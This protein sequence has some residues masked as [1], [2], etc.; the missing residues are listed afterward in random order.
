MF[1]IPPWLVQ[2]LDE[3]DKEIKKI[4]HSEIPQMQQMLDYVFSVKGKQIRPMMTFLCSR[5]TGKKPN[6]VQLAAVVEICHVASLIHDD[7]IDDGEL[8]RGH[9]TVQKKY[10]KEMAVYCGDYMIFA[11]ISR[12][13]LVNKLW[14]KKVFNKLEFMCNG[15]IKQ[16]Y[17]QHNTDVSEQEYIDYMQDKTSALFEIACLTGARE[18]KMN[19][20][21]LHVIENFARNFGI[22][23]QLVDDLSDWVCSQD[24]IKKKTKADFI[25]GYY[26]LPVIYTMQ[27]EQFAQQI[28]D[29]SAKSKADKNLTNN[30]WDALINAITQAGG[31]KY[32]YKMIDYYKYKTLD[33][34]NDFKNSPYKEIL[35]QITEFVSK[36]V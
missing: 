16:Y 23:F 24:K 32:T 27:N 4:C 3:T 14:Y 2:K 6:V 9:T 10:G 26:T 5:L 19:R 1:E 33:S 36:T 34:L 30:D 31:F 17:N 28:C 22:M 20:H 11:A 15:E 12:T 7:I 35:K 8:R 13:K 25:D 29:L 21:Q 18:A